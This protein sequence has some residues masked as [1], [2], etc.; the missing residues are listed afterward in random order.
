MTD[1]RYEDTYRY[2][3]Y[4][5]MEERFGVDVANDTF[6]LDEEVTFLRICSNKPGLVLV[7]RRVA[8]MAT[9]LADEIETEGGK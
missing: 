2:K 8:E 7:L 5:E 1:I 6:T 9:V 3:V 4:H